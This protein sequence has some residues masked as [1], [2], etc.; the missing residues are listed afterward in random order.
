[1][2]KHNPTKP[3]GAT[4]AA[5]AEALLACEGLEAAAGPERRTARPGRGQDQYSSLP[6][7]N[8]RRSVMR[9]LLSVVVVN[10]IQLADQ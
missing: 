10:Q 6:P 3:T 8:H 1:V 5:G 9:N 2:G 4:T 7:G